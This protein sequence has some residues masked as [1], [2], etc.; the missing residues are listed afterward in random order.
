M[1]SDEYAPVVRGAL[2]L[3][4]GTT[5]GVK[6]HKKKKDKKPKSEAEVGAIE[7]ALGEGGKGKEAQIE[8]EAEGM[9]EL[10]TRGGDGK[11]AA[12]RA[13]EEVRRRR[14]CLIYFIV[15]ILLPFFSPS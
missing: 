6:K 5:S 4:G 10:E 2:R 1:P 14:V 7:K 3:K 15:S 12:E 11:T 9:G 13:Y 8:G